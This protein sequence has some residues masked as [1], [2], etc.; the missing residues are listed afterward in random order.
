MT[1]DQTTKRANPLAQLR[2]T[3]KSHQRVTLKLIEVAASTLRAAR[4][5]RA[6]RLISDHEREVLNAFLFIAIGSYDLSVFAEELAAAK[7]P[8]KKRVYARLIALH[9]VEFFDKVAPL[10]GITLN[11][12]TTLRGL[13]EGSA[14]RSAARTLQPLQRK[15]DRVLRLLRVNVI[16]HRDLDGIKQLEMIRGVDAERMV[17]L[18]TDLFAV[19]RRLLV[20]YMALGA[21]MSRRLATASARR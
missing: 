2:R 17:A 13:A 9:C 1:A 14:L 6:K 7:S 19:E 10:V 15:Y 12:D 20:A 21:R 5:G 4:D 8:E 11:S 16:A 18:A 3:M